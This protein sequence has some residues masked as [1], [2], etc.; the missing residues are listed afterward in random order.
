[1]RPLSGSSS[2]A[3]SRQRV[4]LPAPFGPTRPMRSPSAIRH[5]SAPKSCCPAYAF[6]MS[7][8]W[9][10]REGRGVPSSQRLNLL[11]E[12]L[13]GHADLVG[14]AV[15]VLVLPEILLGERT[16]VRVGPLLSHLA[17][18]PTALDV[19]AGAARALARGSHPRVLP[20]APA[21]HPPPRR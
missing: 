18:A 6:W 4:V 13:H 17:D 20:G 1:M 14:A 10:M 21:L 8:T 11:G 15:R 12:D 3:R 2:P 9:I 19:P 16:D 5:D 7:S